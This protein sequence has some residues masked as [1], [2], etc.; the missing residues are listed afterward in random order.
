LILSKP[1]SDKAERSEDAG[2]ARIVRKA[3]A[4][5]AAGREALLPKAVVDR[6]AAGESEAK[7]PA[8]SR[9]PSIQR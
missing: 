9:K 4:A 3:K 5:I 7:V 1:K 8:S 2:T 6:L